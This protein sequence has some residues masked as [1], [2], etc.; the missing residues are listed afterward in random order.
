MPLKSTPQP[1]STYHTRFP[2]VLTVPCSYRPTLCI[3]HLVTGFSYFVPHVSQT[4]VDVLQH[5]VCSICAVRDADVDTSAPTRR[6]VPTTHTLCA[7]TEQRGITFTIQARGTT[8]ARG[9]TPGVRWGCARHH[10][11]RAAHDEANRE[12]DAAGA[13]LQRAYT[14]GPGAPRG[15][16]AAGVPARGDGE[17]EE[18]V[19]GVGVGAEDPAAE[20]HGALAAGRSHVADLPR[21]GT[22]ARPE[23]TGLELPVAAQRAAP[24]AA[25][26]A[27]QQAG[28]RPAVVGGRRER[29]GREDC[30]LPE[31]VPRL[32]VD[33][34]HGGGRSAG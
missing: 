14:D 25:E 18:P 8:H 1:V 26:R 29:G 10:V 28:V 11:R 30:K 23:A 12:H 21:W 27:E 7:R 20:G 2:T 33:Q 22:R 9:T 17:H 15:D 13:D 4:T 34:C 31:D 3:L 6:G 32:R 19:G 16:V 24:G 5:E